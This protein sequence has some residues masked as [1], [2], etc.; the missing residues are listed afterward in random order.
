MVCLALVG[1]IFKSVQNK[2]RK[3]LHLQPQWLRAGGEREKANAELLILCSDLQNEL[4]ADSRG[5]KPPCPLRSSLWFPHLSR[6]F[7]FA[8]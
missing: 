1:L 2:A 8:F 7:A 3:I 6:D 4:V 5:E